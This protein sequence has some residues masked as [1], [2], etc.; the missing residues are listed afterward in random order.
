MFVKT[1]VVRFHPSSFFFPGYACGCS[2]PFGQPRCAGACTCIQQFLTP[3]LCTAL[4]PA[5]RPVH[6]RFRAG[7]SAARFVVVHHPRLSPN[8]RLCN[9]GC[10]R[11]LSTCASAEGGF[12]LASVSAEGSRRRKR[13][14]TMST[15]APSAARLRL[16]T[17]LKLMRQE[18]PEVRLLP[19]RRGAVRP[20][21]PKLVLT[22]R[23]RVLGIILQTLKGCSASPM[24]EENLFVWSATIFGPPETPWEGGV[25]SLRLTFNDQ[26]PEKPPR[27]RFTAEMFHPNVYT[28]GT[29]CLDIIQDKW[30][31]IYVHFSIPSAFLWS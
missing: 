3:V 22:L 21:V 23:S 4:P 24:S 29:L 15:G 12:T 6:I 31:P 28:D 26:Y 11:G 9:R 7:V 19:F 10:G 14:K 20:S 5:Y 8:K 17:D 13:Q 30:S 18:P 27:V 25:Y 2:S 16:M 1:L